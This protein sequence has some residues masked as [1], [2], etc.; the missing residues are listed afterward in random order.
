MPRRKIVRTP[1]EEEEFQRLRRQ[2]NATR[3]RENRK[4]IISNKNRNSNPPTNTQRSVVDSHALQL[5]ANS[6]YRNGDNIEITDVRE[7]YM[8][9]M[10]HL[11]Q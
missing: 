5:S 11:C 2:R 8:R 6:S 1:D 9:E 10:I 3:M 7:Q 4:R